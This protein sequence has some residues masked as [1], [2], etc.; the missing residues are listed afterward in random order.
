MADRRLAQE[1]EKLEQALKQTQADQLKAMYL[2]QRAQGYC[3]DGA[4][5][6]AQ[7]LLQN[8][9]FERA[10]PQQIMARG[11]LARIDREIEET[12]EHDSQARKALDSAEQLLRQGR[13]VE[14]RE[15]LLRAHA[16]PFRSETLG[17]AIEDRLREIEPAAEQART[18]ALER[19]DKAVAAFHA[20]RKAEARTDLKALAEQPAALPPELA[21]RARAYLARI[22]AP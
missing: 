5:E 10:K 18:A 6:S 17:E 15:A 2:L 12:R 9:V 20:G 1:M 19:Y 3:Q 8:P 14:A 13:V 7:R 11:L 22:D 21:A 16:V 4:Y